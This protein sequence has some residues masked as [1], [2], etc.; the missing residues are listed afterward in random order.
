MSTLKSKLRAVEPKAAGPSKPKILVFGKPGVGKTWT[1]LDFPSCYYIDTEGGADLPHYTERLERAGGVY[2][3]PEQGGADF[4][5][6][7]EQVRALTTERH[8]YRT[9][10]VDSISKVFALEIAR[11]AERMQ[12]AGDKD[13]FGASKK[14][15]VAYMRA[16]VA[17]IMRLDMNVVFIAHEIEEWGK[18]ERGEREAV[19]ATFDAWP[20]LEYE[21]HLALHIV[22]QGSRR[23]ARVRKTRLTGFPDGDAFPW[24]YDEFA[25]RYGRYVIEREA[26]PIVPAAP[27][28][29]AEAERLLG[30]VKMP[31][32]WL[33]RGLAAYGVE[34]LAELDASK[35]SNLIAKLQERLA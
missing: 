6:I 25:N 15:A 8:P 17:A 35:I 27:E 18:N 20:K 1:A 34:S 9:L 2:L 3:G 12:R 31:D 21:L 11:E 22:R 16:L 19:G 30:V 24:S 28:Q 4:A 7:I 32:D 10:V 33:A 14:P 13:A 23:M 29:V 5:T 26:A